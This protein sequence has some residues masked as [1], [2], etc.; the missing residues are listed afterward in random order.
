MCPVIQKVSC[1]ATLA[2]AL[3]NLP[4]HAQEWVWAK[5]YGGQGSE[6]GAGIAVDPQGNQ[7]LA[8]WFE[9]TASFG[10][11]TLTVTGHRDAFIGKWDA[12]GSLVWVQ[13]AGGKDEDYASAVTVDPSGNPIFMGTFRS[14]TAEFGGLTL[15][16]QYARDN[17]SL[18]IAK[19]DASG[20]GAWVRQVGG[21]STYDS[22]SIQCDALGSVYLVACMARFANFGVTNLTG[23][24]EI[25]VAK[26]DKDGNLAWARQAGGNGYD[27]GLALAVT[28]GGVAY[29]TGTF[30]KTAK[31]NDLTLT[32]RGM[33]DL[34]LAKY[35]PDG[36]VEWLT[37]AG[38]SSQ[39]ANG[40]LAADPEGG[41]YL[42]GSFQGSTTL[43]TNVLTAKA[44]L[45]DQDVFFARY[46]VFGNVRWVRQVGHTSQDFD[47]PG[48]VAVK[49]TTDGT[50][51]Y[52]NIF[53]SGHFNYYATV[54]GVTLTNTTAQRM[55]LSQWSPEGE[56]LWVRQAGGDK[57]A[58]ACNSSPAPS[59]YVTGLFSDASAWDTTWLLSSG[60]ADIY[61][62]RLDTG[63]VGHGASKPV[64]VQPPQNVSAGAGSSVQLRVQ[65]TG[66]APVTYRWRRNGANLSD[67]NRAF[68]SATARLAIN[69][70]QTSDAGNY[71]VVVS[72]G[73]GA[74]TSAVA[75]VTIGAASSASGP[76]WNWV[77]TI[78]GTSSDSTAAL[79]ADAAGRAYAVGY[80][81][82]TNEMGGQSLV[83]P[84]N[85][86]NIFLAQYDAGGLVQWAR[87]AGGDK[88][89][90][91]TGTAVDPQGNLYITGYSSSSNAAFG[92]YFLTNQTPSY[93]D[94][95]LA[96]YDSQG[97]AQWALSA[98][99]TRDDASRAVAIDADGNIVIVGD[100]SSPT[101]TLGNQAIT[102]VGGTDLFVAKLTPQ[103]QLLWAQSAGYSATHEGNAVAVD[104][105]K[106]VYIAGKFWGTTRFGTNEF[107]SHF[108]HDTFLAKY[109]S[110]GELQWA[111]QLNSFSV[112]VARNLAVD[113]DNNVLMAGY[114]DQTCD[115][116]EFTLIAHG[117]Q[118]VFVAK[119]NP[120]GKVLWAKNF[121]GP[122]TETPR[123]LA[124]DRA[125]NV[126][127]VGSFEETADFGG[128][129][130]TTA[131]QRDAFLVVCDSTG[132]VS[133]AKQAGGTRADDGFALAVG[134]AGQ[135]YMGGS[136]Q[137]VANFDGAS[138]SANNGSVDGFLATLTA[139]PLAPSLRLNCLWPG[140]RLQ[141]SGT[142]GQTITIQATT[143][144]SAG[145]IW[146]ALAQF[147]LETSP[148]LWTD[149]QPVTGKQKYYRVVVQP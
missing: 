126:Y 20:K 11:Q 21:A 57:S 132:Q 23:Y 58:I 131:G 47:T 70:A 146:Q 81:Q 32:S 104:A 120:M 147:V 38:G 49:V 6:R 98:T 53:L 95:F 8:G 116:D 59:V 7:Y 74:V 109:S 85:A 114:L 55:Y 69:S 18:F 118:D 19:L 37:Q 1:I 43:G 25:L 105:A 122:G 139:V 123:S 79:A 141:I 127:V 101:L 138:Y 111:R 9:G 13:K 124:V 91:P 51:Y 94:L 64:V 26:Y 108:D 65:V 117:A 128:I 62:A 33:S 54:G 35:S 136:F 71:T 142:P 30:E 121:G 80:F 41:V 90:T 44:S 96:K 140:N 4:L 40:I 3:I 102:N 103:G 15:T 148:T 83:A 72:N 100:F 50:S 34:F 92:S 82:N 130:L 52:T 84:K 10:P 17:N 46:D 16:N 106:N 110:N 135:I 60:N 87:K 119:F 75:V 107:D 143:D 29:V 76:N 88:M 2:T 66:T 77:R 97:L 45:Y 48:S 28:P 31:F 99:G 115:F 113:A 61:H 36:A 134:P 112:T 145:S 5:G 24:E 129:L 86:R 89:D 149:P 73:S 137:N 93:T 22:A 42:G 27:Y 78:G 12:S 56:V 63:V 68:G 144:L 125:N 67:G 14:A 39:D 133:W